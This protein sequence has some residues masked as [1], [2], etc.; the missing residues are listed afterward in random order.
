VIKE[1]LS[2][3]TP[4]PPG[5]DPLFSSDWFRVPR[6]CEYTGL[7]QSILYEIMADPENQIVSFTL[8]LRKN[9]TRGIRY[10]WR[11]SLDAFLH[12]Q[13]IAEGIDPEAISEPALK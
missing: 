8:R 12:R 6:A 7:P 9:Q 13:A 4:M 1:H 5:T 10:I 3:F 11:P 2:P